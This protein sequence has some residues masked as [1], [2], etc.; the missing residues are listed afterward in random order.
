VGVPAKKDVSPI[1][2]ALAAVLKGAYKT[3]GL[4][5]EQLVARTGITLT[6]MQRLMA[7]KSAFDVEQLYDIADAIEWKSAQDYLRDAEALAKQD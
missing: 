7:G 6:T 4:T 2:R 1:D 5:Q 3:R